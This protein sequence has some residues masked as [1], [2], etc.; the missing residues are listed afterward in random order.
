MKLSAFGE[1]FSGDSGI[2]ELMNDLGT[3][4]NENPD[5]I[6]M[7]GGNP[8]RLPEMERIFQQRLEEIMADPAQRHSLF[9]IYQS[10]QGD[11]EF[12]KQLAA[13]L[14]KQHGWPVREENIAISNGS[15]SAF[16]VLFNMLAGVMADGS[17]R[18]IHL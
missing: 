9:G 10:P 16:F 4:L 17:Q 13:L 12:R 3:A 18:N 2:V 5:M 15:Q 14:H 8:G 6:F 7:G 1:K 11:R